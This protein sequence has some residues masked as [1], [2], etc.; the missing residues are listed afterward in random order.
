MKTQEFLALLTANPQ[1]EIAFEYEEGAFVAKNYHITEIKNVTIDSVD[2]GKN[3]HYE[4]Q[5]VVQL[6]NGSK[7]EIANRYMPAEKAMKIFDLVDSVKPLRQEAEIFFEYG[8]KDSKTSIYKIV[9]INENDHKLTVKLFV[10]P[11]VCKPQEAA[12]KSL[13]LAACCAPSSACC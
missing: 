9:D 11:T 6:K 10:P 1:K 7:V 12:F 4:E 13:N 2:C 3:V 8:N 5:T